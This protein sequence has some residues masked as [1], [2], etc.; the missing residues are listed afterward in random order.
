[1]SSIIRK[2]ERDMVKANLKKKGMNVKRG[3]EQ[4]WQDHRETKYV[5]KDEE[6]NIIADM[7]PKNTQKKKQRHFDNVEQY[8]NLFA[9]V[10]SLKKNG[11]ETTDAVTE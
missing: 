11:I 1:M 6:G 2:M 10:D 7:T 4:A 5:I 8:T 3:F 9:Y